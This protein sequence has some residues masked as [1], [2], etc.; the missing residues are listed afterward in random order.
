[1]ISLSGQTFDVSSLAGEYPEDSLERQLLTA[2]A[3]SAG[4]YRYDTLN[5]LRFELKLRRE[6]VNAANKLA[7]SG[8]GFSVFY[9]SKCN[10]VFWDRMQNGAFKL[11]EGADPAEAIGDIYEN[12]RKYATECATA[13][14][15]VY[16][17]ALLNTFG[18]GPFREL[19]H[20]IV[21]MNW[22]SIDPLLREV[23][24][25]EKVDGMLPGDRGYFVNP[26][27][28]PKTPELQGE[29]VIV[30]PGGLYYGH[31]VGIYKA[32][33]IIKMLNANRKENATKT[34]YLMDSAA[35]PDFKRLAELY[36]DSAGRQV[37]SYRTETDVHEHTHAYGGT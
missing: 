16:Y 28:D 10:P 22:H 9:K 2:M 13:M 8:L 14:M 7:R 24:R 32:E 29:N 12:G 20:D 3:E 31:G 34:A 6:I 27:V 33:G 25:P 26:D 5:Q 36:Y 30:M 15:I 35:R 1:M 19:F 37:I 18:E 21:L 17:G 23:G 4:R 11:K